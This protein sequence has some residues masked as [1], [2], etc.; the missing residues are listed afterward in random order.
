MKRQIVQIQIWK[1]GRKSFKRINTFGYESGIPGIAITLNIV[2]NH[3]TYSVTHITSG[4]TPYPGEYKTIKAAKRDCKLLN[5]VDWCRSMP[6]IIN[7]K[8]A[9]N[10]ASLAHESLITNSGG[11]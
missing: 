6:D 1:R 2:D 11:R 8:E 4:Q 3:K 5:G 7:D 9:A 10:L